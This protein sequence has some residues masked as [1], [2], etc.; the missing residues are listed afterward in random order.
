MREKGRA[1]G[2]RPGTPLA[3]RTAV[4]V[5]VVTHPGLS[6][7]SYLVPGLVWGLLAWVSSRFVRDW[8]PESRFLRL[9]PIVGALGAANYAIM[10]GPSLVPFALHPRPPPLLRALFP[11]GHLRPGP[12][13]A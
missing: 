8:R 2:K 3:H 13:G 9:L 10:M 6:A 1:T 5:D 11:P 4:M 7:I 12:L